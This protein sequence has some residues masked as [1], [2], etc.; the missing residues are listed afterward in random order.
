MKLQQHKFAFVLFL[1]GMSAVN[2]FMVWKVH[3]MMAQGYGDFAAFYTAGKIVQRGQASQLYDRRLQWQ[4]QQQF[5][6]SVKTRLGPLPYIRPP[7]E[8]LLFLPLAYFSY[9]RAHLIWTA[10]NAIGLLLFLFLLP[11]GQR[12]PPRALLVQLL[13]CLSLLPVA[14]D[15]IA[16][17][18]AILLL[19]VMV[20]ALHFLQRDLDFRSGMVLGL[21]LFKFNFLIPIILVFML[22][23]KFGVVLGFAATASIFTLISLV[24]IGPAALVGYPRYLWE[25]SHTAGVG[26]IKSQSMPSFRGL[27]VPLLGPD[28]TPSWVHWLL[29]AIVLAGAVI[30][31][32]IWRIDDKSPSLMTAGFSMS[33]VVTIVT[34]YYSN[35]YDLVLLLLP[36]LL[37]SGEFANSH[38]LQGWPRMIFLSCVALLLFSPLWWIITLRLD[39]FYIMGALLICF[40]AALA[41]AIYILQRLQPTSQQ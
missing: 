31:A 27:L 11:T 34:S 17:Q 22:R 32:R 10:L 33:I 1:L 16:G 9:P 26:F 6:A 37:L 18:D 8:A 13:V 40:A 30:T 20:I 2:G 29:A 41:R 38:A 5:A 24:L 7:F 14:Y 35:S 3:G 23:R 28:L 4:V 15:F 39:A 21:G 12:G 25:L 36:I 19:L